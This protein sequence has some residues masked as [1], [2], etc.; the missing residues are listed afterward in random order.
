MNLSDLLFNYGISIFILVAVTLT[1]LVFFKIGY[2]YGHQDGWQ[3]GL[4]RGQV[5]RRLKNLETEQNNFHKG[6]RE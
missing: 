3:E 1:G 5:F 6:P 2:L 4:L